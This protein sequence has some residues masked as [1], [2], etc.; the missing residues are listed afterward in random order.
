MSGSLAAAVSSAAWCARRPGARPERLRDVLGCGC[1]LQRERSGPACAMPARTRSAMK[2]A[3]TEATEA[4]TATDGGAAQ[5]AAGRS[6][7]R[8]RKRA[9]LP[10]P[11]PEPQLPPARKRAKKAQVAMHVVSVPG[12]ASGQPCLQPLLKHGTPRAASAEKP[13]W[14]EVPCELWT[15]MPDLARAL[16]EGKGES[17]LAGRS[18]RLVEAMYNRHAQRFT[19]EETHKLALDLWNYVL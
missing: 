13:Q 6:G 18:Q 5:A 1:W 7:G 12:S 14:R 10:E 4:G 17:G 16:S 8:G 3:G 11:E 9:A 19:P 15:W 2:T